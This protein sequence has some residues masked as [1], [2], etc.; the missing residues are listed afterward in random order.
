M[1]H[2]NIKYSGEKIYLDGNEYFGCDFQ[3]CELHYSGGAVN[4]TGCSFDTTTSFHFDGSAS[5]TIH[6]MRL[7]Y[8]SGFKNLIEKTFE[9]I[10][11]N[12]LPTRE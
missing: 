1:E 11:S 8:H 6:F 7:L 12:I 2:N 4:L 3:N 10:R 5:E 9:N